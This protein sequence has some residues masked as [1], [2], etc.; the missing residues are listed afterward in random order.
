MEEIKEKTNEELAES[1]KIIQK[2]KEKAKK[3]QAKYNKS[4]DIS[5]LMVQEALVTNEIERRAEKRGMD[6]ESFMM[7]ELEIPLINPDS[8]QYRFPW[9]ESIIRKISNIIEEE[10]KKAR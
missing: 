1:Y 2:N 7:S 3:L 9:S 8:P 10:M 4:V 5:D 6:K